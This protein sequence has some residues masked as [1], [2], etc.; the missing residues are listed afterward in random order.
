MRSISK[1]KLNSNVLGVLREIEASGE[2]LIVTDGGVPAFRIQP[3]D[4]CPKKSVEELF[5]HLQGKVVFHGDP[6]APT[7]DEWP[8][9]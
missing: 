4:Q 6:D 2:E 9:V 3:I 7:I 8:D 1:S 5:G